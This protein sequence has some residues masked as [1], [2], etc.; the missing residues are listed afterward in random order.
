MYV[1][2]YFTLLAIFVLQCKKLCV[3]PIL[4]R[5]TSLVNTNCVVN[6]VVRVANQFLTVCVCLRV[7]KMTKPPQLRKIQ[8]IYTLV[9]YTSTILIFTLARTVHGVSG[10]LDLQFCCGNH[11]QLGFRV[12]IK[13]CLCFVKYLGWILMCPFFCS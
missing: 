1:M 5:F 11:V 4:L 7:T 6:W 12:H 8:T 13:Y 3:A 9:P 2:L 10:F